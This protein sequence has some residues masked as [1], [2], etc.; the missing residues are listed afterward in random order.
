MENETGRIDLGILF[1]DLLRTAK[2]KIWLLVVLVVLC[3]GAKGAKMWFSYRPQY[4]ATAS[5]T[6]T[7]TNP[8]QADVRTYNAAAAEQ[9]AKTFPYI[10]TSGA[11]SDLVMQDLGIKVMPPVSAS[12]LENTNIFSLSVTSG[13][14]QFAYDV[15]HAVME[16]YPSIAEFV[17]GPTR[18]VLLDESGVPSAP[19]NSRN[20]MGAA[21]RGVMYGCLL[22]AVIVVLLAMA[23]T[24]VHNEEELKRLMNLRCFG[25]LPRVGGMKK[26]TACPLL[27]RE[28][29]KFGFSESV[30]LIRIRTE[31]EMRSRGHK[32]LLV[33]SA[34]PGEGKT[35]LAVNLA[36]SLAQK[37]LRTL[38][39]DC[40]LR[41]PSVA[42]ALGR[43]NSRGL[44]AYLA[45]A[46]AMK[47][48]VYTLDNGLS[49]AFGGKPAENAAELLAR[50][51]AAEFVHMARDKFDYVILDTPPCSMLA[52]AA[53]AAELA[54][55]A[56]M[57]IRQ[58][59]AP[60][61]RIL[62]GA[63]ILTDGGLPLI[64]CV[65]G[66][67]ERSRIHGSYGYY[68]YGYGYGYGRYY[69]GEEEPDS[70]EGDA[71]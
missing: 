41:N 61:E 9:M 63:Q 7:V 51:K 39:V 35:T 6:V 45:G 56:L 26:G 64:G 10:L 55:C 43:E 32:V 27:T 67:V 47:D 42:R 68:G 22:W 30:R 58:N 11:L 54:D 14:A 2:R 70:P 62:E 65:L 52:D 37:G 40:D 46:A 20:L 53:E 38:L 25:P 34:I 31:K 71:K 19:M 1:G 59:Y 44:T 4:Q 24:T 60:R 17:V 69:H 21:K 15:L 23:R 50:P 8:L 49:V 5:F 48:I 28:N 12:V 36:L 13:D 16:H 3:A 18:M 66:C 29:D 57:V 33:S